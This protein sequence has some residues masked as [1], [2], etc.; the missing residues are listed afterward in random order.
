MTIT[1]T[2]DCIRSRVFRKPLKAMIANFAKFVGGLD[3]SR[4]GELAVEL[5]KMAD[6]RKAIE[7]GQTV[8]Q[9]LLDM[10]K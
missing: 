6:F 5:M 9:E 1:V 8:P 7:L 10:C 3:M 2:Y 4:D